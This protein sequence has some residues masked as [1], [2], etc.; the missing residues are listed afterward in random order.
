MKTQKGFTLVELMIVVAI[1]GILASVAIPAYRNYV[2]RGYIAE[3]TSG[4][5]DGRVKMEQFFLDN[6]TYV[7]G[8]CP[9]AT[10][11]FTFTGCLTATANAYTL[12]ATGAGNMAG[13]VYTVNQQNAKTSVITATGW[14]GNAA[15]WATKPSG[16]C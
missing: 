4:L 13:F 10:A 3:A 11:R 16:A 2:L 8:P 5:S 7:G 15:C 9:A 1:I 6:R 12:T 14:T